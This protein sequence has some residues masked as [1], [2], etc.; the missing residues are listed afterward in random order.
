MPEGG[1]GVAYHSYVQGPIIPEA[2]QPSLAGADQGGGHGGPM[3]PPP[4]GT[5]RALNAEVY[6]ALSACSYSDTAH[7]S[8]HESLLHVLQT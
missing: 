3:P 5:E 4:F 2:P 1:G 6:R 7:I 8:I